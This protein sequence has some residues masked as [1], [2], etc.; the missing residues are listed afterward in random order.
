[1]QA[2]ALRE[3]FG[4]RRFVALLATRLTSQTA[5]GLFQTSLAG[6]VLFNP[7]HHT[8]PKQVAAGFV[9]LL[10]P[11]SLIGPFAGVLLD[12]WRRQRVLSYGAGVRSVLVVATAAELVGHGPSGVP[13]ALTALAALAINRFYLAALSAALP[14]VVPTDQL[15]V[16]NALS[17]TAGTVV[18]IIG[19][20]IGLGLRSAGGGAD[21]GD[22]LAAL[23]GALGY[24]AAALVAMR[25]PADSL[26]PHPPNTEPLREQLSGIV[27]RT[28]RRR[29][30]PSAP[31]TR[32][33]RVGRDLRAAVP[34]RHLVD[35]GVAALPQLLPQPRSA[36]SRPRRSR[37][38]GHGRRDRAGHRRRGN[39]MGDSA[40]RQAALDRRRHCL[41][42]GHRARVRCALF[43]G[44]LLVSS[45]ALG[46]STQATKVCVDTLVQ[47]NVD[48]EFRGR[49]FSLYDTIFNLSF[50]AAAILAAFVLPTNGKSLAALIAMSAG[51][52]AIAA[53]YA[54]AE[55]AAADQ[56]RR[57]LRF[58]AVLAGPLVQRRYRLFAR[59]RPAIEAQVEQVVVGLTN[60]RT[61]LQLELAHDLV[62]VEVRADLVEVL[63]DRELG[64]PLLER[65]VRRGQ[66]LGLSDVAGRAVG[67]GQPMQPIEQ[68]AG[69]P[70]IAAHRGVC[71]GAT[72]VAMKPQVQ[73]DQP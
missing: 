40:A 30:T 22:A 33:A 36:P 15:V 21:H 17:P 60:Q 56:H 45:L 14:S 10:L 35:H 16:A 53:T 51:Y 59:Q 69:V 3:L 18:T 52:L 13:F 48:D 39:A 72:R 63:L 37:S 65:V 34:V 67:A 62:A 7:E 38:G 9:I 47:S 66:R 71:P 19:A 2:G 43:D 58:E 20:G 42:R 6:A 61:W 41:C 1:M 4:Q 64:D 50:V 11:Y 12:R 26:G 27:A 44:L 24:A 73:L 70:D 57:D 25:L 31:A 8:G 68:R 5:D 32:G 46:F 49:V 55:S 54:V 29:Q 23:A 28:R